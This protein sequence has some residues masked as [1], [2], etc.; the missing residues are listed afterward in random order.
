M[1]E[2]SEGGKIWK[3]KSIAAAKAANNIISFLY[4]NK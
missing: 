2:E 3:I 4:I 1:S